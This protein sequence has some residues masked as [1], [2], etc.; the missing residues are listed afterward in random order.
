MQ[1]ATKKFLNTPPEKLDE[2]I[3]ADIEAYRQVLRFHENRY[4]V[5][6]DP[7]ISDSEYDRLYSWLEEY[8]KKN[9]SSITPDSP[10]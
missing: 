7:L 3:A 9:P 8:E 2:T 10:T 5:H 1:S 4:Y 6:N